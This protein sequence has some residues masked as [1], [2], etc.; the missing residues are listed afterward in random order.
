MRGLTATEDPVRMEAVPAYVIRFDLIH[1]LTGNRFAHPRLY[2]G[3]VAAGQR[4]GSPHEVRRRQPAR[5]HAEIH[6]DRPGTY[7]L[8]VG[9]PAYRQVSL[10]GTRIGADPVFRRTVE[11]LPHGIRKTR[12]SILPSSSWVCFRI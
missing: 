7:D 12:R 1:A 5:G 3:V 9:A 10:P 11:M 8:M 6:V 2:V 4:I